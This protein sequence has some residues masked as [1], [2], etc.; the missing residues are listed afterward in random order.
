MFE[1]YLSLAILNVDTLRTT[2]EK[3]HVSTHCLQLTVLVSMDIQTNATT[4]DFN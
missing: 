3:L 2:P 1:Q 4:S